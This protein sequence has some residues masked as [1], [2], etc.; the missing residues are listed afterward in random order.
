MST[1]VLSSDATNKTLPNNTSDLLSIVFSDAVDIFSLPDA[2]KASE[3]YQ[4]AQPYGH[5][6]IDEFFQPSVLKQ[7]QA[8]LVD[9]EVNFKKLFGD[10]LQ[11]NKT[12]STGDDVP[13]LISL[14][15]A[16]FASPEMLRYL[17]R[18]TGLKR[19]IP[20]PYY[21]TDYGYYHIVGS[22]GILASHVDH[23]RHSSLQIPHVLNLVVY[24]SPDWEEKD[25]GSLYL[26]DSSG[27]TVEQRVSCVANRAVIFACTPTAFHGVEPVSKNSQRR[28]HSLYFAY[29]SVNSQVPS[30]VEAF[31]SAGSSSN[32]DSSTNYGTYFI[33]P[34][35]DLFLPRNWGHLRTRLIYIMNLLLPPILVSA[36]RWFIRKLR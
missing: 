21:N 12:I 17:E 30:A 2:A 11:T 4:S 15:A 29:Y 28:R 24:L 23:S 1:A 22:G 8:E 20:D 7:L 13:P 10:T 14:I 27:K 26:Y 6:V 35:K 32:M 5:L 19:L 31:P 25:G 36:M 3:A 9:K 33:V 18:L 16:K 34:F